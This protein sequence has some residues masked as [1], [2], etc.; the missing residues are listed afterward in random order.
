[1][2]NL[3]HQR[4]GRCSI[5]IP[6]VSRVRVRHV[7]RKRPRNLAVTKQTPD[8]QSWLYAALG[9]RGLFFC[10]MDRT[11]CGKTGGGRPVGGT[12]IVPLHRKESTM[13]TVS[14]LSTTDLRIRY[15]RIVRRRVHPA[16]DNLLALFAAIRRRHCAPACLSWL[17]PHHAA[18][19]ARAERDGYW[20]A[21]RRTAA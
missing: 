15:W 13:P 2:I 7:R 11:V 20:P 3:A 10:P 1:M 9:I 5:G 14:R 4:C 21:P 8:A 12:S 17:P 18:L 19:L 6:Q 16:Q